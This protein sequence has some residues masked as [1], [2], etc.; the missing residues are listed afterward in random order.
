MVKETGA[1]R[2]LVLKATFKKQA[3]SSGF[4]QREYKEAVKSVKWQSNNPTTCILGRSLWLYERM[5]LTGQ[6]EAGYSS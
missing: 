6:K 3:L 1:G 4:L 2:G 5:D